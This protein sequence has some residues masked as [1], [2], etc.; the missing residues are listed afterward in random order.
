VN[1]RPKQ[2]HSNVTALQC[3]ETLASRS[4][5][6]GWGHRLVG[7]QEAERSSAPVLALTVSTMIISR[8]SVGRREIYDTWDVFSVWL[9]RSSCAPMMHND[10]PAF[11][12]GSESSWLIETHFCIVVLVRECVYQKCTVKQVTHIAYLLIVLM[13][14]HTIRSVVLS[15]ED[16]AF[17]SR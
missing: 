5:G 6:L 8:S 3:C 12:L 2:R 1:L 14:A 10:C 13:G 11:P 7:L 16:R 17:Y 9:R 4:S 15:I